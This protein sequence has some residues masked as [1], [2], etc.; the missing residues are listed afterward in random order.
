M[1]RRSSHDGEYLIGT[2]LSHGTQVRRKLFWAQYNTHLS[3]TAHALRCM[4][5]HN[6]VTTVSRTASHHQLVHN[7]YIL[8][9][10]HAYTSSFHEGGD[11]TGNFEFASTSVT[12]SV[13]HP[14]FLRKNTACRH[15]LSLFTESQLVVIDT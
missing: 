9:F 11:D 8:V 4:G 6:R 15:Y 3:R 13:R 7:R 14:I 10:S 12:N 2:C 1:E 5:V